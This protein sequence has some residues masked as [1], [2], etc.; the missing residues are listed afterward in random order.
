MRKALS[1]FV[2]RRKTMV[3]EIRLIVQGQKLINGSDGSQKKKKQL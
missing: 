1:F 3:R 2:Q